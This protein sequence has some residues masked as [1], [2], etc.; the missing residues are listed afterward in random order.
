MSESQ[1][2]D[3]LLWWRRRWR[4]LIVVAVVALLAYTVAAA[5]VFPAWIVAMNSGPRVDDSTR[6][7]ALVDTR[8]ALLGLLAPL[9][10]SIGAVA[11]FLNYRET[12]YQNRRTVKLSLKTLALQRQGQVTDRFIRAIDQLGQAGEDRFDT[13]VGAIYALEQI[14][15]DSPG[16]YQSIAEILTAF[17]RAHAAQE[18]SRSAPPPTSAEKP[19]PLEADFQAAASALGRMQTLRKPGNP[20]LNLRRVRLPRVHLEGAIL[21]DTRMRRSRLDWADLEGAHLQRAGLQFAQLAHA[22]LQ[23]ANL[24]GAELSY[25]DLREARLGGAD[26]S[27]AD[28]GGAHLEGADLTDVKNLTQAQVDSAFTNEKTKLPRGLYQP[29]EAQRAGTTAEHGGLT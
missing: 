21:D 27:G 8:G 14:A 2:S 15:F 3:R 9:V 19:P 29:Q 23:K 12:S 4:I 6:L 20:P 16:H 18:S 28:L 17:L 7:R 26:L 25:A 11:A 22:N 13:R 5:T 10:V 24:E 1:M